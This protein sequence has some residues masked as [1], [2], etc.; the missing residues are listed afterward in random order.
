MWTDT[1]VVL[2]I[3]V[4]LNSST[5]MEM[6]LKRT[7][8]WI[9]HWSC[10][11][12]QCND[13][14]FFKLC[15]FS[16]RFRLFHLPFSLFSLWSVRNRRAIRFYFLKQGTPEHIHFNENE[17]IETIASETIWRNR[18]TLLCCFSFLMACVASNLKISYG[19]LFLSVK[20]QWD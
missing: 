15:S 19:I 13:T 11:V 1:S 3:L 9:V 12:V 6:M 8:D 20:I 18:K 4:L 5:T 14:I 7:N 2:K 16:Q 10:F 17:Q